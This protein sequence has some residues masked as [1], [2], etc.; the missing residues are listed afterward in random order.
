MGAA[1]G[2]TAFASKG[3]LAHVDGLGPIVGSPAVAIANG[4]AMVAWA[5]RVSADEPWHLR[6]TRFKTGAAP[7]QAAVFQPPAGGKGAQA[8]SPGLTALSGGRFLLV[9]TEGPTSAHDVR[10][11]TLSADG[12]PIGA[13]LVVSSEGNNAGQGQAAVNASGQGIIAFLESRGDG[14]E[15]AAASIACGN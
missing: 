13:P 5:D 14:F 2:S 12:H 11:Q 3:D 7:D 1:E 15:V 8:M 4:I 6:W 9:W 10:A